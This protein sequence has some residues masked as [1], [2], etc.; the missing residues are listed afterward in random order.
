M[1]GK[2]YT[3]KAKIRKLAEGAFYR[4]DE[5]TN[6]YRTTLETF[7]TLVNISYPDQPASIFLTSEA[8]NWQQLSEDPIILNSLASML[9]LKGFLE[10][11]RS[12]YQTLSSFRGR[13]LNFD[14]LEVASARAAKH[15]AFINACAGVHTEMFEV[16]AKVIEL[17]ALDLDNQ[18]SFIL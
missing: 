13:K 5:C 6:A 11:A 2:N 9:W 4:T 16:A 10:E 14:E 15:Q 3:F 17:R 18:K 8:R 7:A 1:L 12:N